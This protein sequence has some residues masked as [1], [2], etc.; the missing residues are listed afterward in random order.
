MVGLWRKETDVCLGK[1]IGNT[2]KLHRI[3]IYIREFLYCSPNAHNPIYF[4]DVPDWNIA[5][6]IVN[7]VTAKEC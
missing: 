1:V 6:H 4:C 3:A 5:F 7:E 2:G